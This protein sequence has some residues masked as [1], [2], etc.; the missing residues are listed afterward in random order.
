MNTFATDTP[1]PALTDGQIARDI[2]VAAGAIRI[3]KK[4]GTM[5]NLALASRVARLSSI[6]ATISKHAAARRLKLVRHG[7]EVEPAD[8]EWLMRRLNEAHR[9]SVSLFEVFDS[10]VEDGPG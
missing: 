10:G 1:R 4:P 5:T 3:S 2:N 6:V 9:L 8:Q 7:D